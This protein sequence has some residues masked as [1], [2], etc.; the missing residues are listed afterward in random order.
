MAV[1][2]DYV[3]SADI[4]ICC[5]EYLPC[6]SLISSSEICINDLPIF[7]TSLLTTRWHKATG[8]P[9][10]P[11]LWT[12]VIAIY[13]LPRTTI[14]QHCA[15]ARA[16]S[17]SILASSGVLSC[18][19]PINPH[20]L[21]ESKHLKTLA[22]RRRNSDCN[23]TGPTG[24]L[25]ADFYVCCC[26]DNFRR[27]FPVRYSNCLA[28]PWLPCSVIWQGGFPLSDREGHATNI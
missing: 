22:L 24:S 1:Q 3:E 15:A 2:D 18:R 9:F 4:C 28:G 14:K 26:R 12:Q 8:I 7:T 16:R 21:L 25:H 19:F 23:F 5:F 27:I 13:E 11:H 6:S 17:V 20:G 10:K